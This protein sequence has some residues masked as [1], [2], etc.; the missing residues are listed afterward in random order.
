MTTTGTGAGAGREA[1]NALIL[2]LPLAGAA[3]VW[4]TVSRTGVIDRQFLP[5][6]STIAETMYGLLAPT[7]EG[8]SRLGLHLGRSL[9]RLF[10]GFALGVF[11]GVILGLLMGASRGV[12]WFLTPV[13]TLVM[14]V[15]VIALVPLLTLWLGI[16]DAPIVAAVC[17][18]TFFPVV[19]NTFNGVRGVNRMVIWATETMGAGPRTIFVRVLFPA[20]LASILTGLKL[21]LGMAWRTLVGAEM[22]IAT[23]WGLG[24]MIFVARNFLNVAVM[25]AGIVTLA[26][27]GFVLEQYVFNLVERRTV[28]RWGLVT[29]AD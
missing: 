25:F 24:S 23:S 17:I 10:G 20:S 8:I 12:A 27:V 9:I 11:G 19:Y 6:P 28:E 26:V 21:G 15:P 4:E 7:S 14:S 16:G 1:R 13:V 29:R 3:L 5:P 2:L 22:L 18:A